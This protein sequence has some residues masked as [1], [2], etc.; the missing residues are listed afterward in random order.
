MNRNI[1]GLFPIL[2]FSNYINFMIHIPSTLSMKAMKDIANYVVSTEKISD[3]K[4]IAGVTLID[5]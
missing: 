2:L 5:F 4:I 3:I 1:F